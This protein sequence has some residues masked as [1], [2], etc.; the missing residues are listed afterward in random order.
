MWFV[1]GCLYHLA[2]FTPINKGA[3]VFGAMFILQ[4][5]F[6][7]WQGVFKDN[8]IFSISRDVYSITG[9]IFIIYGFAVYPLLGM[10]VGHGWPRSPLLGVAPC[11]TTIFTYGMFLLTQRRVPKLMLIV[12]LL[13][14]FVGLSAAI[15]FGI[16]ED[17]GLLLAGLIGTSMVVIRD[18]NRVCLFH[19]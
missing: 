17:F 8:L 6:F 7:L 11:P 9:A 15:N 5:I 16:Y 10:L 13:W 12:P 2:F 3:Y 18:K 19:V 4:G 14:S 1:N